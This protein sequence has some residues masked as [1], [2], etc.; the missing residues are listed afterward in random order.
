MYVDFHLHM[1]SFFLIAV[2]RLLLHL[3]SKSLLR[4]RVETGYPILLIH[5]SNL[6]C[7]TET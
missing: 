6:I 7:Y 1:L 3:L 2:I 4:R 5:I